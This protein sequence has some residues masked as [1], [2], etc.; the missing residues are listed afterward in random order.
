MKFKQFKKNIQNQKGQ[1]LTE[2]LFI[3]VLLVFLVLFHIQ[4]SV[5]YVAAHIMHYA[6]FMA[7]R[8]ESVRPASHVH[9]IEAMVGTPEASKLSPIAALLVP[10]QGNY[11]S[12]GNISL[13]YNALSILPSLDVTTFKLKADSAAFDYT[14][15]TTTGLK[16]EF[17]NEIQ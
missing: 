6:S 7:A 9:Y 8:A 3:L 5:N 17:D 1:V 11:I 10:S 14:G 16:G 13:E 12:S 4:S 15:F 2:Y